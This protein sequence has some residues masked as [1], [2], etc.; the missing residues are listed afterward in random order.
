MAH[1]GIAMTQFKEIWEPPDQQALSLGAAEMLLDHRPQEALAQY[2]VALQL[3]PNRLNAL[4]S[5][6]AAAQQA[7][8]PADAHTYYALVAKQTANGSS[9]RR[10]DVARAVAAASA[11]AAR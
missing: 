3:S 4:L 9:S 6:A 1:W 8:L 5:A 11:T 10:P 7:G 2:R